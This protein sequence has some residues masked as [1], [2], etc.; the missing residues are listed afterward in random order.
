M[1]RRRSIIKGLV[2]ILVIIT[3]LNI[4]G[5]TP[6][7][8]VIPSFYVTPHLQI[9]D[10]LKRDREFSLYYSGPVYNPSAILFLYPRYSKEIILSKKWKPIRD[11][12]ELTYLKDKLDYLN[13][14]LKAVVIWGEKRIKEVVAY[15]YTPSSTYL[16]KKKGKYFLPAVDEIFNDIYYD[17]DGIFWKYQLN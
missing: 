3:L 16:K 5:C 7:P 11:G 4:L 1:H 8:S 14:S 10:I 6:R 15:L 2:L 13:A 17:R 9:A 12:A